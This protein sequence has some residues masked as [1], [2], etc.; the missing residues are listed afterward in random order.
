ML[1]SVGTAVAASMQ[2]RSCKTWQH[3]CLHMVTLH[4]Q[5][6]G[7]RFPPAGAARL[8]KPTEMLDFLPLPALKSAFFRWHQSSYTHNGAQAYPKMNNRMVYAIEDKGYWLQFLK[9]IGGYWRV[10]G[11]IGRHV[12]TR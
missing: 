7:N 10:L 4:W 6:I 1:G 2:N 11:G 5:Q 3:L 12:Q 8:T 9:G